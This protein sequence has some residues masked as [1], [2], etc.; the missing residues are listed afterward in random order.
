MSAVAA[1]AAVLSTFVDDAVVDVPVRPGPWDGL[2]SVSAWGPGEAG[3]G[4]ALRLG[5]GMRLRL[6]AA[7]VALLTDPSL[8][9]VK[10]AA[11]LAAVVLFAKSRA[12]EGRKDDNQT[13]I[14]GPELGRWLGVK[15]STI[16][17]KV[18]PV[19]RGS[20][21]LHTQVVTDAKGQP[22]GLN[23]LM[24]PLWAARKSG[25][26]AHP[27]ALSKVELAVL[28]RLI[29][30]LF[31]PGWTLKDGRV[32]PAG[33]LAGRSGKG[34]A[35]DRLGLLLMV[36]NTR[37]SGWLQLC[38]GS[39][40]TRE[41]RGAATLARLLGCSP[42]GARKVLARLEEAGVVARQRKATATRMNGRG[43]V[44]LLP[45][46][47]AYGRV[48]APV[49]VAQDSG[50]VFSQ[51][52]GGAVGD[53][54][55][56]D[57]PGAL[58]TSG[59]GSTEAA[60][61]AVDQERPGGAELHT[62]HASVVTPVVPPQL[63]GGFSGEGRGGQG[64][65]PKRG[66][67][68]EDQAVSGGTGAAG[69]AQPVAEVG[70]LRGEKPKNCP[71]VSSEKPGR[72]PVAGGWVRVVGGA[73]QGRQQRG[74]VPLPSEDLRAVLAPVGLLWARLERPAARRLVEAA[75]RS[76]LA[77]VVGF[78]GR[79][80]A[81]QVLADRLA[82]RLADQMR[83]AGPIQDPVGWLIGLALPQ[84]QQCGDVRCD[85]RVLLDSGRDCPRCEERQADRRAQRLAVAAAVDAAMP[86]ASETERRTVT[87]QQL[88]Q[89]VTVEAWAIA[90]RWAEVRARQAEAKARSEAAATQPAPAVSATPVAPVVLPVPRPAGVA[91]EPEPA[92]VDDEREL[93]L[94]DLTREQVL[95]WRNRAAHDH[96]LVFDHIDRYGETSAR[97]LFTGRFVDQA[98][99]LSGLG[100]LDL[101]Y[102]PWGQA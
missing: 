98:Q 100:H 69:S 36:L 26:A 67:V 66:C 85:D 17:H 25:G 38:G 24:M 35:T 8:V 5:R 78:A 96:Q 15:E 19:L 92:D 74:R 72:G 62:D 30:V 10:D 75:A 1:S 60:E 57:A 27:L 59:I 3:L 23:C 71:S 48:L 53:Q 93:V 37:A 58:G 97:R 81:P 6:R 89:D 43:R 32:I 9:G 83:L 73:G 41:G 39:V 44:M 4:E 7:V 18:L 45:V 102:T 64:R 11:K 49:E 76:E 56:A 63:S 46:A 99:R 13:S 94:E 33:L 50:M 34:A 52:P 40:K 12:P 28:L 101:G 70:P 16:H 51:R 68:R 47:R 20:D 82:R 14:R 86:H 77:R 80:D 22:T 84:R 42:S 61:K 21:A 88:H 65:R 55:L 87:E 31:G 2:R 95:D 79:A 91:A 90:R 54:A 29:E